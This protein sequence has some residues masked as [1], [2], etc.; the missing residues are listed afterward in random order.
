M[1]RRRHDA[2]SGRE[3]FGTCTRRSCAFPT[4]QVSAEKYT[5]THDNDRT[6]TRDGAQGPGAPRRHGFPTRP[7][8]K[9]KPIAMK[10]RWEACEPSTAQVDVT[11]IQQRHRQ[12]IS[13]RGGSS[14][15]NLSLFFKQ[16]QNSFHGCRQREA[17]LR[18]TAKT[19]REMRSR[20]GRRSRAQP[21]CHRLWDC[22]QVSR[23]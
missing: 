2:R 8:W 23:Q 15:E 12:G 18:A 14:H 9:A 10:H 17:F 19:R 21:S 7:F 1:V 13:P 5:P 11:C 3:T 20:T 16:L 22:R 6:P 4:T